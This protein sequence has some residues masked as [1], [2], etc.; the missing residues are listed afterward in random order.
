MARV[1]GRE[2]WEDL[3]DTPAAAQ[4]DQFA[5]QGAIDQATELRP[6]FSDSEN[7]HERERCCARAAERR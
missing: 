6:C 1:R 3:H 7:V 2:A 4:E 5:G